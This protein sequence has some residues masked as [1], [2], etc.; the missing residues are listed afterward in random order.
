M[1]VLL[2]VVDAGGGHRAAANALLAAAAERG[3]PWR[4]EVANVTD[5]LAPLDFS[6]R[7]T[8]RSLEQAY[9]GMIRRRLTRHLVPMLRGY[10]WLIGRLRPTLVARV[11]AWLAERKPALVVSLFPNLN[12]VLAEAV[13]RTHPGVPFWVALTDLADFPP[14][15]WME[16]GIDRVIVASDRAEDQARTVGLEG[17]VARVSGMV[18]HPRF[19]RVE[20]GRIGPRTRDELGIPRD[21]FTALVLFGG[22]GS[23]EMEGLSAALLDRSPWWHVVAICGDNPGLRGCLE[24]LRPRYGPRLHTLGFTDRVADYLSASDVLGTKPGPGTLAEA[25][26]FRV[27]AVVPCNAYTIPQERYNA[28]FLADRELGLVVSRWQDMPDAVARLAENPGLR[29]SMRACLGALPP[30]RAVH[31]VLDLIDAAVRSGASALPSAASAGA[32]AAR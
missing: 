7:L 20:P 27:P 26:H 4:L 10:Q 14:R 2:F 18:L 29:A 28:R 17:R 5:V 25:F 3:V 6:R 21:A 9:N 8:G 13:H 12:G 15:F 24:G 22:K 23:P 30:N 1:D 31:E 19:Y 11:A 32:A 16:S